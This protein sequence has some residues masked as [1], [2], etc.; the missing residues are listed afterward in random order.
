MPGRRNAPGR[1]RT[2]S[3]PRGGGTDCGPTLLNP[4]ATLGR[5]ASEPEHSIAA[6]TPKG[7]AGAASARGRSPRR[8][9]GGARLGS[10]RPS[11]APGP[12][13][14]S[15]AGPPAGFVPFGFRSDGART[16]R[17]RPRWRGAA[18]PASD[19]PISDELRDRSSRKTGATRAAVM[20][21]P[22]LLPPPRLG[23]RERSRAAV[24]RRTG[25]LARSDGAEAKDTAGPTEAVSLGGQARPTADRASL[26]ISAKL[27]SATRKCHRRAAA[28]ARTPLDA[29]PRHPGRPFP[30]L[31]RRRRSPERAAFV[32]PEHSEKRSSVHS[33]SRGSPVVTSTGP[34]V[35]TTPTPPAA[36]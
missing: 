12:T 21:V 3:G 17:A 26:G 34:S 30:V 18:N 5:I 16:R 22:R 15:A 20:R 10:P 29:S 14:G 6:A 7:W 9:T 33:R 35:A 13:D 1:A 25:I 19:R 27:S 24:D 36:S 23:D 8:P 31:Q 32:S 2:R 11:M 28:P 4:L